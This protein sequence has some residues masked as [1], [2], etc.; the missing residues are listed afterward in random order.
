VG[1][2]FIANRVARPAVWAPILVGMFMLAV[3]GLLTA[4]ADVPM[5][6]YLGLGVLALGIWLESGRRAD[7]IV[8]TLLLAGAAGFKN[9]GLLG[10]V[11]AFV[12]GLVVVAVTERWGPRL[13]DVLIAAG[14]VAIFAVLRWRVWLAAHSLK[15]DISIS[16]GL[17]P[18]FL[19]HRLSRVWPAVQALY[20]QL[21]SV[22]TLAV[23]VPIGLAVVL[24]GL[25]Q[26][27]SRRIPV[28][29]LATGIAYFLALIWAYWVSPIEIHFHIATSVS[30]IY[31]GISFIAVA[32]PADRRRLARG[33]S[34]DRRTSTRGRCAPVAVRDRAP[35]R[36]ALT[37]RSP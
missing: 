33:S 14:A 30:R 11:A 1:G 15:G 37:P 31:V 23:V 5:S 17:D 9:E 26:T 24:L 36:Q 13:K 28:F 27:M 3:G 10:C 20:G 35:D 18:S 21:D 32:D 16:K 19:A 29:Y 7:L 22:S 2:A 6:I 8:A 34:G 12:V 25:R 4:Y